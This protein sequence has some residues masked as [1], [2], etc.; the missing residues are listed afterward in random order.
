MIGDWVVAKQN[1]V[2]PPNRL[3]MHA[4]KRQ[5]RST[6]KEMTKVIMHGRQNHSHDHHS[7]HD[8]RTS[9]HST[10]H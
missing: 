10:L 2:N 1:H 8:L 7:S 6:K 5:T 4:L 9:K 3:T